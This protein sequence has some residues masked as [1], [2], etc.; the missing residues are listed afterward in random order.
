MPCS[1]ARVSNVR[2][3]PRSTV[4]TLSTP[5]TSGLSPFPA[6][7]TLPLLV[8]IPLFHK[9]AAILR[10]NAVNVGMG[11]TTLYFQHNWYETSTG[12]GLPKFSVPYLSIS[13]SLNILLTL[14]IVIRLVLHGR[15]I[16]TATGSLAGISRLYKSISAMLIESCAL[17]SMASLLVV[18]PLAVYIYSSTTNIYLIGGFIVEIFYP[19]LAEIQV[20][21]FPRRPSLD[22]LSNATMDWAGDRSTA[23]YS[24]GRQWE[25]VDGSRHHHWT[26]QFVQ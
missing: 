15:K 22:Q 13:V 16:R 6:S 20:R 21:D 7:C 17:F 18:G 3:A 8:S 11:I 14:M 5:Q 12:L 26:H 4:A 25:R 19:I 1:L 9:H 10:T 23:H 2:P 24:A